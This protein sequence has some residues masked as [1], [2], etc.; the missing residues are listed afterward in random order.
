ML[1]AEESSECCDGLSG[2]HGGRLSD[3]GA[4]SDLLYM[5]VR[6]T[7]R[8]MVDG[9][10]GFSAVFVG[11]G[12]GFG[13]TVDDCER[14]CR[15][16][17]STP[18]IDLDREDLGLTF[19]SSSHLFTANSRS[20][21]LMP[22]ATKPAMVAHRVSS[23]ASTC[24]DFPLADLAS[25]FVLPLPRETDVSGVSSPSSSGLLV[26]RARPP[27]FRE[28]DEASF[29][30]L[31]RALA[32]GRNRQSGYWAR[33]SSCAMTARSSHFFRSSGESPRQ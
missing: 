13:W 30:C 25:S 26:L 3:A 15:G 6:G 23:R 11:L 17:D 32:A 2:E 22:P 9:A 8:G 18:R 4:D 19:L 31:A 28:V 29:C 27:R 20:F 21:P 1:S 14:E 12:G 16:T 5:A 24:F 33:C 7:S 10:A